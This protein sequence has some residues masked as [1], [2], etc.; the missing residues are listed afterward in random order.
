MQ[1]GLYDGI[2]RRDCDVKGR[3]ITS[4]GKV[5]EWESNKYPPKTKSNVSFGLNT[6]I[7]EDL[8]T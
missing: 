4:S 5:T 8:S 7:E 6:G 1:S 3:S 2:P